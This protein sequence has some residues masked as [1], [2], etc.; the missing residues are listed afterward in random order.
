MT[1]S[2]P[3]APDDAVSGPPEP[4]SAL[5]RMRAVARVAARVAGALNVDD[6]RT[7]LREACS[8]VISL[9]ALVVGLHEPEGNR[10]RIVGSFDNDRSFEEGTLALE[11]SVAER[12]IRE[13]RSLRVN[14]A[15][16]PLLAG[17]PTVG[18]GRRPESV[19]CVPIV[20]ESGVAGVLSVQSYTPHAYGDADTE[21][22][23]A[24]A[25]V[26][27][28]ALRGI[29]L[30]EEIK[31][32]RSRAER[33]ERFFRS[34]IEKASDLTAVVGEDGTFRYLSP[35]Y[36]RLLGY[37]PDDLIGADVLSQIHP[38]DVAA[39]R[40]RFEDLASDPGGVRR[41]EFRW[42]HRDGSWLRLVAVGTNLAHDPAVGGLVIN[43][44]DVTRRRE[45]VEALR[46]SEARFRAFFDDDLTGDYVTAPDGTVLEA[47]RAFAEF[48]GYEDPQELIGTNVGRFYAE[49]GDRD[50][51]LEELRRTGRLER[52]EMEFRDRNGRTTFALV[53]SLAKLDEVGE[54]VRLHGYVFDVTEQKKLEA[55]LRE[56]QRM[57]AVGRLAG[58]V[59]H[60]FNNL[61]TAI[62][63][64]VE[65]MLMD[66]SDDDPDR[67]DLEEI[68][69]AAGRASKMTAQL[70]A[71]SRQQTLQPRLLDLGEVVERSRPMLR[72]ALGDSVEMR[73]ELDDDTPPVR[74]DRTQ[75]EQVLLNLVLNGRDAMEDG[76][77][78]TVRT[79]SREVGEADLREHEFLEPGLYACLEV[80]DTG[81]GM[82]E[83]VLSHVFEPFFTTKEQGRGTG[84][85][86]ATVYGIVKQSGG[87]ILASSEPE[88]GS[89]FRVLL[90]AVDAPAPDPDESCEP[91]EAEETFPERTATILVIDDEPGVRRFVT[92]V[93]NRAGHDVLEAKNA[94]EARECFRA[95]GNRVDLLLSDVLIP[96]TPAPEIA[97]ELRER[98]PD[99]PVM[100]MSGFAGNELADEDRAGH[101]LPF[102]QKPFT[103]DEL[104]EAV[105]AALEISV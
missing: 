104:E 34:L 71:F 63:G 66:R 80:R 15:K 62:A 55:Q 76:G 59:A 45:A 105:R 65:L 37:P 5:D 85:G 11:G 83:A 61:L 35:A 30:M 44:R 89:S 24:L 78:L 17:A 101:E 2:A 7:I 57:E 86:L 18:T 58:G 53:N 56:A 75:V 25:A 99:L 10:L 20:V 52:H 97:R 43:T 19:I 31:A 91:S 68:A 77:L 38:E 4:S 74:A 42:R 48:F 47:N 8:R 70:L 84:L 67:D 21:L 92:R 40:S 60:D 6:L 73:L 49:P 41:A 103:P 93:L 64:N 1:D 81:P 14:S 3:I 29:G 72:R 39:V 27:A 100:Y 26:A 16:E 28:T 98:Q 96:G 46:L 94:A 87:F 32:A 102:L 22:L 79:G 88:R 12:V 33:S 13:G 51:Y 82:S 90:P 54:I 36:E 95:A 69:R 50:R 23:E 9:D